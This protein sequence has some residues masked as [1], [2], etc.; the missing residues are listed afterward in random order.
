ML[1]L[2]TTKLSSSSI[3]EHNEIDSVTTIIVNNRV[4]V[5]ISLMASDIVGLDQAKKI[6]DELFKK[7]MFS[8]YGIR[9]TS[10]MDPKYSNKNEI[11]PPTGKVPYGL[12]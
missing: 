2:N 6:R 10:S 12:M 5:V 3:G 9:S 1:A 4:D 11:K 7:D 8:N